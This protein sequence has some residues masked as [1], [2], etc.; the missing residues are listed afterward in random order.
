MN[1]ARGT[2]GDNDVTDDDDV[3]NDDHSF[4]PSQTWIT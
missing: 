1:R 4:F 3:Q 2:E